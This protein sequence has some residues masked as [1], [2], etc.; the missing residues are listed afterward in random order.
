MDQLL[1]RLGLFSIRY[2]SY[3]ISS[4]SALNS[5]E[6]GA[7]RFLIATAARTANATRAAAPTA[8]PQMA[9]ALKLL[10]EFCSTAD[11]FLSPPVDLSSSLAC[12]AGLTGAAVAGVVTGADETGA[13]LGAM[14]AVGAGEAEGAAEPVG[15][16]EIVGA[17]ETV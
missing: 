3:N 5:S 11:F 7:L 4:S 1:Q 12:V 13:A 16:A 17:G 6:A 14:D 15:S 2:C 9:P 8:I 10:L